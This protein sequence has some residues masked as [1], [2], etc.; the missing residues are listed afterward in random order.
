MGFLGVPLINGGSDRVFGG[1]MGFMMVWGVVGGGRGPGMGFRG[2]LQGISCPAL[3]RGWDR[4]GV[5]G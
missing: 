2:F 4:G 5:G 1:F 3:N